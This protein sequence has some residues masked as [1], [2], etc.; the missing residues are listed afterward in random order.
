M[1][2][3]VAGITVELGNVSAWPLVLGYALCSSLLAIVNKWAIEVFQYPSLL[4]FFQYV[5]CVVSVFVLGKARALDHDPLQWDMV[6]KF[7][8]AA[9]VFYLAIFTNTTLLKYANVDT[10]IV[11]RSSTPILVA[12]A[13]TIFRSQ[14]WPN[15][16]TVAALLV[17]LLGALGY[18][19]TDSAFTVQAYSWAFAY[20][21]TITFEMV[22]IK[23]IVS[24][25]GLN[26]WGFVLYNNFISMSLSPLF[27]YMTGEYKQTMAA[28]LSTMT[29]ISVIFPVLLSCGFGLAISFFGFACRK[30]VSATSFTVVGVT[31]KLL[32]V[33]INVCVWEKHASTF[34][35]LCLLLTIVGGVLY[36]Q[37]TV[38]PYKVV[39]PATVEEKT[40]FKDAEGGELQEK[41][42]Q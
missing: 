27:W 12:I 26:T 42:P 2:V 28:D 11:F 14:P 1:Q 35:I 21:F 18:V 23:H 40:P 34:G 22:Y 8:P 37:S 13:D 3:K 30:A 36:Q 5:T 29:S 16:K 10:F 20:L 33:I 19:L 25:L 38:V 31:N 39:T 32:T 15:N 6:K 4:T 24:S 9:F 41:P 7:L 17:I